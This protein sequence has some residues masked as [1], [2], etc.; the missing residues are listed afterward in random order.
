ML[1]ASAILIFCVIYFCTHQIAYGA[2]TGRVILPS[3]GKKS[4]TKKLTLGFMIKSFF[5]TIIDP[6]FQ[7]EINMESAST[8]KAKGGKG[9]KHKLGAGVFGEGG[10]AIGGGSFGPVCG[11]NGCK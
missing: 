7:G 6:T 3:K 5:L 8:S 1:K 2:A 4:G 11:P 9:K 10:A